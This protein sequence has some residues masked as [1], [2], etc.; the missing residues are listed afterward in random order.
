MA[1]DTPKTPP[2]ALMS[3]YFWKSADQLPPPSGHI[4]IK[5]VCEESCWRC[6]GRYYEDDDGDIRCIECGRTALWP[7][8]P[9]PPEPRRGRPASAVHICDQQEEERTA[10][11]E[12]LR[13][14]VEER[15]VDLEEA[16]EL[17]G[18]TVATGRRYKE[19][20]ERDGDGSF[21][22]QSP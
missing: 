13:Y 20:W 6:G 4:G 12:D 16:V 15:G 18:V 1:T 7:P 22:Q 17:V 14:L 11:I 8:R 5:R 2:P 19:R 10:R 3:D 21:A 9:P